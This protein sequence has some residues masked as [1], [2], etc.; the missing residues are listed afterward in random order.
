MRNRK[1]TGKL[2][3]ESAELLLCEENLRFIHFEDPERFPF[4][5]RVTS[6]LRR[7]FAPRGAI[8]PC[9]IGAASHTEEK[10]LC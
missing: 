6:S 10:L 8:I 1:H 2:S 4:G 7:Q 9:M 5:K 3:L